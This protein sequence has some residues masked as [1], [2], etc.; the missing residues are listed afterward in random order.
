MTKKILMVCDSLGGGGAER[1]LTLT[2]TSVVD[3][4]QVSVFALEGGLFAE[5][6]RDAGIPLTIS[7]R[8][9]RL[10][11]SPLATLWKEMGRSRPDVVHSWGWMASFASEICCRR[12]NIPHVSG[13]IRRGMFP[14]RRGW[15]LKQASSLGTVVV[16]NSQAGL[17]AFGVQ[18]SRGRVLYNGF[19]PERFERARFD[20]DLKPTD[21]AGKFQV[22][23]AATMDN[24]K[25]FPLYL[26]AA[27]QILGDDSSRASFI[28]LGGGSDLDALVESATDLIEEGQISFPGRVPEVMD[29][30]ES[31]DV[32][33]MLSTPIH[34][35]GLSNSIMEYMA[36]SLPVVCTDQGGNRELV[37]DG[38]TGF[39]VPV[40]DSGALVEKLRWLEAHRDEA[41][42]MGAA[43]R[44]RIGS[45]FS[46]SRMINRA[47]E[48]Y[49]EAMNHDRKQE[50]R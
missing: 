3:P 50:S 20:R 45:E 39:L 16:A 47:T 8:K 7:P 14:H 12:W 34:G 4:W 32:G 22:V 30:Y 41:R 44:E 19:A 46:I 35:E 17:D 27:R 6:M 48:I 40:S 5:E 2:A 36:S 43:G 25:D 29:F 1:Q 23:M 11:P 18:P 21:P 13:V 26:D 28:A 15:V 31:A 37:I 10:D 24:R 42:A 49:T 38:V 9:F 33:V